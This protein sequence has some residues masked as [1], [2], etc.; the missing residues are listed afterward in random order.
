MCPSLA[1]GG[2]QSPS[3]RASQ[4]SRRLTRHVP[5]LGLVCNA[6][7]ENA[8]SGGPVAVVVS[9]IQVWHILELLLERQLIKGLTKRKLLVYLLLRDAIVDDVEEALC[10]DG[11]Y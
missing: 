9:G 2:C 3:Y 6:S 10:A 5:D 8:S 11:V 1:V 7:T 4:D